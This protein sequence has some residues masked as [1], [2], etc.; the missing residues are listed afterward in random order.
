MGMD[1]KKR[2]GQRAEDLPSHP[3]TQLSLFPDD[4]GTPKEDD[5]PRKKV[6]SPRLSHG[7]EASRSPERKAYLEQKELER[8]LKR[9]G[10][11]A[12][13]WEM[14]RRHYL[15]KPL[16]DAELRSESWKIEKLKHSGLAVEVALERQ[17]KLSPALWLVAFLFAHGS[18]ERD[19]APMIGLHL[20]RVQELIHNLRIIVRRE[21]HA[22]N[23]STV[24]RW[25][26]GL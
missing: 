3:E 11:T 21:E 20:R 25:L 13:E 6:R 8:L 24:T 10:Y 23:D 14:R 22:D 26:L 15:E 12:D 7:P 17:K 9:M 1:L 16:D 19:I 2:Q 4:C 5:R 18:G